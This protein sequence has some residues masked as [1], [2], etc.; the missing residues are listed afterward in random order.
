MVFVR[1][2]CV[3]I[4]FKARGGYFIDDHTQVFPVQVR[5]LFL[6]HEPVH[7]L[8]EYQMRP[9][10]VLEMLIGLTG[11]AYALESK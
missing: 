2:F 1:L 9:F 8:M 4:A 7:A 3:H 10:A 6:V 11:A 5:K